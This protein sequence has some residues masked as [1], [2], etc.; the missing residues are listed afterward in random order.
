M[1]AN[2]LMDWSSLAPK[3]DF[4]EAFMRPQYAAQEMGKLKMENLERQTKLPYLGPELEQALLAKVLMNEQQQMQNQMTQEKLPFNIPM[5]EAELGKTETDALMARILAEQQ[6]GLF[7]AQTGLMGAQAGAAGAQAQ[8]ALASA[9]QTNFMTQNPMLLAN[10]PL[11]AI[12]MAKQGGMLGNLGGQQP[13]QGPSAPGMMGDQNV[14]MGQSASHTPQEMEGLAAQEAIFQDQLASGLV[15]PSISMTGDPLLDDA[16]YKAGYVDPNVIAQQERANKRQQ[17]NLVGYDK[18]INEASEQANAAS[19][20]LRDADSFHQNY[21][22][23]QQGFDVTTGPVLG[24]LFSQAGEYSQAADTDSAN[25]INNMSAMLGGNTDAFR[26]LVERSKLS[27]NM[28][29]TA[30]MHSYDKIVSEAQ[31]RQAVP[32]FYQM[33][34]NY[35]IAQTTAQ[36]RLADFNRDYPLMGDPVKDAENLKQM[37]NYL[38]P[39]YKKPATSPGPMRGTNPSYEELVAEKKRRSGQ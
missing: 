6:P 27:T 8:H 33:A 15:P 11:A 21:Q 20:V 24:R 19:L 36:Q 13:T 30:E 25:L 28:N 16:L 39:Q 38:N 34:K 4:F 17:E 3:T 22:K 12:L 1:A 10:S 37:R 31:R 18:L 29:A 23:A 5:L 2:I 26:D 7:Q 9:A 14:N 32:D 35:G